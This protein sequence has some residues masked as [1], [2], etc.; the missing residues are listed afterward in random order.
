MS[1]VGLRHLVTYHD[2]SEKFFLGKTR[3]ST[4]RSH[5]G[6]NTMLIKMRAKKFLP[7]LVLG[8]ACSFGISFAHASETVSAEKDAKSD[9]K[10]TAPVLEKSTANIL[11][12]L[13]PGGGG[14][15]PGGGGGGGRPGG[16]GGGGFRPGGGGGGF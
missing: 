4:T 7:S 8:A 6:D 9:A 11:D 13:R 15:R 1:A 14:G 10:I 5:R 16:G 12:S 3:D 2:A